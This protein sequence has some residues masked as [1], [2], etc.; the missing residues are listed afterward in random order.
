VEGE[1]GVF[2]DARDDASLAAAIRSFDRTRFDPQQLRVHAERFAP[3]RFIE[4]LR[5]IVDDVRSGLRERK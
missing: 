1:T 5:A 4:R 3:P 2:F